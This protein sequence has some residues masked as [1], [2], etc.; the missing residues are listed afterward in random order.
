MSVLDN[1]RRKKRTQDANIFFELCEHCFKVSAMHLLCVTLLL[2]TQVHI[3][4][5]GGSDEGGGGSQENAPY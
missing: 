4:V 3:E 5:S 2:S 1:L